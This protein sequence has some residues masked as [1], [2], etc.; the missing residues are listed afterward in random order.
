MLNSKA[1]VLKKQ[2]A[3]LEV[4]EFALFSRDLPS[5]LASA[6]SGKAVALLWKTGLL[7]ATAMNLSLS[8]DSSLQDSTALPWKKAS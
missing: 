8:G 3:C 1:R 4:A 5:L 7:E 6:H 2:S